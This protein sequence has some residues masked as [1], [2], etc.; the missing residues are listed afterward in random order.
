MYREEM[1]ALGHALQFTI[2]NAHLVGSHAV[3]ML[4]LLQSL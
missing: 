4:R 3:Q 1:N 2:G